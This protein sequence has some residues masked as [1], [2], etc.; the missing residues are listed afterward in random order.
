ME[1]FRPCAVMK[2]SQL[3]S[4]SLS[5]AFYA[6]PITVECIVKRGL[7]QFNI[8]GMT[9]SPASKSADRIKSAVL[10]C[11]RQFPLGS[12]LIHLAPVD[13]LKKGGHFDLA[14][15]GSLLKALEAA[16]PDSLLSS[17]PPDETL[18]IGELSL[19]GELRKL[20][21]LYPFLLE[22]KRF[23]IQNIVLPAE[24][25]EQACVVRDLHLYPV[26]HL[27]EITVPY[28]K[29]FPAGPAPDGGKTVN[30]LQ[31]DKRKSLL[32]QL[33][34]S[35][36][37]K[38]TLA[39]SA[40][41]W[42]SILMIGPPGSGKST[43]ARELYSLIPA[44]NETEAMEILRMQNFLTGRI[45]SD[46]FQIQR[47]LRSPH[48][49]C[50]SRSLTG[51]GIPLE[52]GEVTKANNG[53]LI[54]DEL[55][56]FDRESLQSLREPLEERKIALARGSSSMILPSR[57]L[58]AATT[59]PCQCGHW[60]NPDAVC[61]CTAPSI[62][63]YQNRIMGP[64]RDRIDIE[65]FVGNETV[66]AGDSLDLEEMEHW[67]ETARLLQEK[68]FSGTP[69]RCNSDIAS[70]DLDLFCKFENE[71]SVKIWKQ[72]VSNPYSHRFSNGCRRLGRTIADLSGAAEIRSKDLLEALS[73]RCLDNFWQRTNP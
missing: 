18:Y 61:T 60:K 67:I 28:K 9:G 5:G 47:P 29:S 32:D 72:I 22:A 40:A 52:P 49:S 30:R 1:Q 33:K 12:V 23:G 43:L 11:L 16:T 37:I 65:V 10:S 42:H 51:G 56:E 71:E 2:Y 50:S 15:A 46:Y 14:L 7:P 21:M 70:A 63:N 45:G 57:F 38:R 54:L 3:M 6:C 25:F 53:L 66:D 59:N 44:P 58:L 35:A 20:D 17:L 62:R 8:S 26:R 24:N 39:V 55:A 48:H 36:R 4:L 19:S 73:Y 13:I 27:R 69:Y 31:F 41:G 34:I 68:R 64:L